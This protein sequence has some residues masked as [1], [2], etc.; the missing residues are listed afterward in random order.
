MTSWTRPGRPRE[1]W[2][3]VSP[4]SFVFE[5]VVVGVLEIGSIILFKLRKGGGGRKRGPV[6][7]KKAIQNKVPG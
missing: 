1:V 4:V 7:E 3:S 5:L 2:I 6:M